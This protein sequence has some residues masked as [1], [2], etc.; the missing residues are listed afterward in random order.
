M[1]SGAAHTAFYYF[2]LPPVAAAISL[3]LRVDPGLY[4]HH[5][6]AADHFQVLDLGKIRQQLIL[7]AVSK[8]SVLFS[9]LRFSNGSTAMLFSLIPAAL[10]L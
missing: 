2:A 4:W 9:S 7:D 6:S 5:R 1:I 10:I 3:R 8:V